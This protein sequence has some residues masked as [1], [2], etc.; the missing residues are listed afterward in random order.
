MGDEIL[1]LN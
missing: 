1:P